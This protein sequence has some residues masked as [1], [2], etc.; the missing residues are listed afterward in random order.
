MTKISYSGYQLPPKIIQQA[1][2]IYVWFTLNS[3]TLR[4]CWW[5]GSEK[6]MADSGGFEKIRLLV[7]S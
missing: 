3:V 7:G 6:G 1:I 2:W 5:N 4:I